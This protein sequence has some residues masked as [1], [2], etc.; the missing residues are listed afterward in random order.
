MV[1][2]LCI[3]SRSGRA[4]HT[5]LS[6]PSL[7]PKKEDRADNVLTPSPHPE[8]GQ[9]IPQHPMSF[10]TQLSPTAPKMSCTGFCFIFLEQRP[11][12]DSLTVFVMS[13]Y[14]FIFEKEGI[15]VYEQFKGQ[16]QNQMSPCFNSLSSQTPVSFQAGKK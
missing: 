12:T 13:L 7:V 15:L 14:L 3:I 2:F 9:V 6:H 4:R 16:K 1:I 10:C 11:D 5:A 8:N